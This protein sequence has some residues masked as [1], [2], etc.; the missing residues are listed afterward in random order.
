MRIR[1]YTEAQLEKLSRWQLR[2]L[3]HRLCVRGVRESKIEL[4]H[5]ICVELDLIGKL[6]KSGARRPPQKAVPERSSSSI[7]PF[8][9]RGV[10][11]QTKA[12]VIYG[13]LNAHGVS[14]GKIGP[15]SVADFVRD[16]GVQ[17]GH[18]MYGARLHEYCHTPRSDKDGTYTIDCRALSTGK[19]GRVYQK[20]TTPALARGCPTDVAA[21][22]DPSIGGGAAPACQ[23]KGRHL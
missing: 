5:A 8:K 9:Y 21:G 16:T 12:A 23:S 19:N 18:G 2:K 13:Y 17:A 4:H 22:A 11:Y 10:T 3:A 20:A 14:T 1:S 7:G 6:V 15:P